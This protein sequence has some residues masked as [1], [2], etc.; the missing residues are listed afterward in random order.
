M[1]ELA[2][3][4]YSMIARSR[5]SSTGVSMM[6]LD[7]SFGMIQPTG[8]I[9]L[10]ETH[11]LTLNQLSNELNS[12][13]S[14]SSSTATNTHHHHHHHHHLSHNQDIS[15]SQMLTGTSLKESLSEPSTPF[16]PL[17]SPAMS[18]G[19]ILYDD[20]E[21]EPPMK[22]SKRRYEQYA[23]THPPRKSD[24]SLS[25]SDFINSNIKS[26]FRSATVNYP[27]EVPKIAAQT[28]LNEILE[29]QK[30]QK[31]QLESFRTL[32]KQIIENRQHSEGLTLDSEEKQLKTSVDS[33]LRMLHELFEQAIFRPGELHR[34][35]YLRHELEV[36]QKQIEVL[37][38]EITQFQSTHPVRRP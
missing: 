24:S 25:S 10:S 27:P 7:S 14:A 4:L 28:V 19:A 12:I 31:L 18:S 1:E 17:A 21:E 8:T 26:P 16:Q 34:W 5:Q 15:L 20:D 11:S 22:S 9:Q 2:E 33:E 32:Q 37:I 38:D 36:Q 13:S 30:K 35:D 3:K 29:L 23:A 6:G